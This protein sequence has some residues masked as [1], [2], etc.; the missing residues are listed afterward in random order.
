[1]H[2]GV[3]VQEGKGWISHHAFN[4]RAGVCNLIPSLRGTRK[5]NHSEGAR[6]RF[7]QYVVKVDA[8]GE[9][10]SAGRPP[11]D[12]GC[13]GAEALNQGQ[14]AGVLISIQVGVNGMKSEAM[15]R[16]AVCTGPGIL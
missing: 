4:E 9:L 13:R 16:V 10:N 15:S 1:M 12:W 3:R 8:G 7:C 5:V 6:I 11:G 2:L 14:G